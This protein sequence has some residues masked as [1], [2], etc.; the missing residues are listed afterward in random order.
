MGLFFWHCLS[1]TWKKIEVSCEISRVTVAVEKREF[2][3]PNFNLV[4]LMTDHSTPARSFHERSLPTVRIPS[5][6]QT[7]RSLYK[8]PR[9]LALELHCSKPRGFY[10]YLSNRWNVTRESCGSLCA[11]KGRL[12]RPASNYGRRQ[13]T[14]RLAASRSHLREPRS[15]FRSLV[16]R[17]FCFLRLGLLIRNVPLPRYSALYSFSSAKANFLPAIEFDSPLY[18]AVS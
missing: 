18:R 11:S 7:T 17:V 3:S 4:N 6:L 15:G 2:G 16:W 1:I 10:G 9:S 13:E 5:L 8:R 14:S 12:G